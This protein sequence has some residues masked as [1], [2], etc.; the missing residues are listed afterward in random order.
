MTK[1]LL[2]SYDNDTKKR[3]DNDT[4]KRYDPNRQAYLSRLP[5]ARKFY[6]VQ[7]RLKG[8]DTPY[9]QRVGKQKKAET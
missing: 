4:E 9:A 8:F 2:Y 5:S 3:Y 1:F 6:L 7:K